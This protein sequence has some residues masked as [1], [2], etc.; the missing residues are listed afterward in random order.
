MNLDSVN[1]LN[2]PL[3]STVSSN[4]TASS[5][6]KNYLSNSAVTF[7][8]EA[9]GVAE[10][11]GT[12]VTS[13]LVIY[14]GGTIGMMKDP[15]HGY[16]PIPGY[17][18][19][20]LAERPNF[21]DSTF[22]NNVDNCV[23]YLSPEY[24]LTGRD[25]NASAFFEYAGHPL[26]TPLSI[27]NKRMLYFILEYEHLLDSSNM[28]M[29]DWIRIASDIERYYHK[30]DAFLVLHGTDTMSYTAS[31][32]SF[33]LENLGKPVI[34]TG[35][36]IPLSELRNDAS[37]N[38]L[39]ALTIAGH[40]VIP[41]VTLYFN[42]RL[43]R[44][45][46]TTKQKAMDFDAFDSL[47][48]KPLARV[49]VN[50]EVDWTEVLKPTELAAFRAHRTLDPNVVT[51]RLFPG[52][53]EATVRA[54][55]QEPIRGIVLE[56]FG[57]GN[58]PNNRPEILKAMS[59]AV[60]RG[61][62]IVNCTQCLKGTVS[63]LYATGKTLHD[64][65]VL[66]GHD[67]TTEAALTKL[68]F[69]LGHEPA[70]SLEEIK[71]QVLENIRG[72]LTLPSNFTSGHISTGRSVLSALV[73]SIPQKTSADRTTFNSILRPTLISLAAS[74]GDL[75]ALRGFISSSNEN[76]L[77]FTCFDYTGMTPLHIAIKSKQVK[78]VE[79]LLKHG[80]SVH[81]RDSNEISPLLLA[82]SLLDNTNGGIKNNKNDDDDDPLVKIISIL[83]KTGATL[84][85][86]DSEAKKLFF[87]SILDGKV[88]VIEKMIQ[89]GFNHKNITDS[90]HRTI[91]DYLKL[92]PESII[93]NLLE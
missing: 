9:S 17:L 15:E 63:D 57:A 42:N 51:L 56:T 40:Y 84:N 26:I 2:S 11:T 93:L 48:L 88:G 47:N 18:H 25:E 35:S 5:S 53:T 55:L 90:H 54:F 1:T 10:M 46:R 81:Q 30:F 36:Q 27:H 14:A 66:P 87:L 71:I 58:A 24:S 22:F 33:L 34:I 83:Q 28:T 61:V 16:C 32:L 67:M 29:S 50:I 73:K 77:T 31:A 3:S 4:N 86:C 75:I 91:K 45:N 60:A 49:G 6:T 43:F 38:L 69:L 89:S 59:E 72:E 44:G 23:L 85:S 7:G 70:L 64:A 41:E 12:Q 80:A 37:D 21:H 39:G 20:T 8:K 82:I 74:S 68:S 52:I 79:W 13:I 92:C 76:N 62:V 65:G 78:C 19:R